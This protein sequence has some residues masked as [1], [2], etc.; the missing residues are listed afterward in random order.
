[1]TQRSDEYDVALLAAMAKLTPD[2]SSRERVLQARLERWREHPLC[3]PRAALPDAYWGPERL[4]PAAYAELLELISPEA[5][6]AALR[7]A[8]GD[9][10]DLVDVGG[11]TGLVA[12]AFARQCPV[13]V[14]EPSAEQRAGLPAEVTTLDGRAEAVPLGDGG[15]DA[16]LACWVLQYTGD[17]IAAVDE[18][19]RVARRCVAIVQAAPGNDLVE[20]YNRA[21]EAAGAPRAHHGWLL[22]LAA[23]RLELAG[24]KVTLEPVSIPVRSPAGG[25][26]QLAEL[27][28]RLH[29]AGH[30]ATDAIIAAIGGYIDARLAEAGTLADDGVLLVA[31]R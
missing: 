22:S 25:A 3:A 17:P 15:A 24:L 26:R 30:P 29:F 8:L 4:D 5:E 6:L 13:T 23:S 11:G 7:G 14:V 12:R 21:A 31:R 20:I 18:L 2:A 19:E 9:V 27:F 10:T 28:A 1:M 16:A